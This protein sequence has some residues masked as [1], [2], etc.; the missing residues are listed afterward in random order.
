MTAQSTPHFSGPAADFLYDFVEHKRLEGFKYNSEVKELQRFDRYLSSIDLSD[1]VYCRED[2]YKWLQKRSNESD[3][4]FSIRNGVYRQF[5]QYIN[6][7]SCGICFP[8]PPNFNTKIFKSGFVP[9]IFSHEEIK[10]LFDAA[11]TIVSTNKSLKRCSPLLFRILYGTGLRINE[12]LSL[13]VTDIDIRTNTIIVKESKNNNSRII[14]PSQSLSRYICEYLSACGYGVNQ[15]LFQAE[16]G[17]RLRIN[18]AYNWFRIILWKAGIPHK[19]RGNGPRMHDLRHTFA[20]HSLQN[21]IERGID[22]NAYLP[23]LCVYLGHRTLAS[24]ERYLRLTAEAYPCVTKDV[25][26]VMDSIIPEANGYEE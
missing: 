10:R 9:Y 11:D 20:V 22:I 17:S 1:N 16:N 13:S 26:A 25:N 3:K 24:T 6:T 7:N 15:P 18:A 2:I 5:F 12:A 8:E 19:G 21:A 23:I 14:V 4:T